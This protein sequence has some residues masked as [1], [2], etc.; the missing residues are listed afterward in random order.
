M[1]LRYFGIMAVVLGSLSGSAALAQEEPNAVPMGEVQQGDP[2]AGQH[3]TSGDATNAG[4]QT[5]AYGDAA[6]SDINTNTAATEFDGSN[7]DPETSVSGNIG[8]V[9]EPNGE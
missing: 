5:Q 8:T 4:Q 6:V 7:P 3:Y 9:A 1:K 2:D